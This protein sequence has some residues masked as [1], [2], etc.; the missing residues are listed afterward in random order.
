MKMGRKFDLFWQSDFKV[1]FE[2]AMSPIGD[3]LVSD[4]IGQ[5][6]VIFDGKKNYNIKNVFKFPSYLGTPKTVTSVDANT[7]L[8]GFVGNGSA[9]FLVISKNLLNLDDKFKYKFNVNFKFSEKNP[10]MKTS[11]YQTK[12]L[13]EKFC[14]SCHENGRYSAPARGNVEA[15]K[16]VSHDIYELLHNTIKG[17]GSMIPRGG[18][19]NCSNKELKELI[20][21][22]L[23]K[24]W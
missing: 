20:N 5:Q 24:S 6:V 13:Y 7:F 2:L 18:C 10:L 22:M 21:F 14:S 8:V 11:N 23:P 16:N 9:Y 12:I 3:L 4:T 17:K 19:S 1:P 15:W